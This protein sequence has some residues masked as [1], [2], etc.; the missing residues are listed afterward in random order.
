MKKSV[1]KSAANRQRPMCYSR[2]SSSYIMGILWKTKSHCWETTK[3]LWM[4]VKAHHKCGKK[5]SYSDLNYAGDFVSSDNFGVTKQ[6]TG[7]QQ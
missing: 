7:A 1:I 4:L 3:K 6:R 5:L 2:S